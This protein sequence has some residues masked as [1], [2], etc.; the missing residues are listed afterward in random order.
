M[1]EVPCSK[2]GSGELEQTLQSASELASF[3]CDRSSDS[4]ILIIDPL[5]SKSIVYATL[6]PCP[7]Q[8]QQYSESQQAHVG[9]PLSTN[10]AGTVWIYSWSPRFLAGLH[11]LHKE[12]KVFWWYV[13]LEQ[14]IY[15]LI[16]ILDAKGPAWIQLAESFRFCQICEPAS[17]FFSHLVSLT[18]SVGIKHNQTILLQRVQ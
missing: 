12:K 5:W 6:G 15:L 14:E 17:P 11:V 18:S 16:N 7:G 13:D 3:F 1:N 2:R 8:A 9:F 10:M 4:D